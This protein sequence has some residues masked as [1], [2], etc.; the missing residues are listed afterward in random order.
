MNYL[1]EYYELIRSKK[2]VVGYYVR[3]QIENFVRDLEDSR[4]IYDTEEAHKRIK[5]METL[6]LQSK[7]PY[8]MQP[9]SLMPWQKAW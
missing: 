9:I 5:F 3:Q 6:C 4:Y 2:V 7:Q 1:Q 8:Y